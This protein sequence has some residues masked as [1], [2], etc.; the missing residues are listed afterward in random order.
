VGPRKGQHYFVTNPLTGQGTAAKWD[1]TSSGVNAGNAEAFVVAAKNATL[2]APT[3]PQD[4]PWLRLT[5]IQGQL[6]QEVYRV[7]TRG[8]Q[9]SSSVGVRFLTLVVILIL[10]S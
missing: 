7:D 5:S 3:G 4:V 2:N 9:L 6:A 1:F 8:G 10:Y